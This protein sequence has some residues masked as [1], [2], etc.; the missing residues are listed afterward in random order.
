V[1]KLSAKWLRIVRIVGTSVFLIAAAAFIGTADREVGLYWGE[2]TILAVGNAAIQIGRN[3]GRVREGSR[4]FYTQHGWR[5]EWG[6]A[7]RPFHAKDTYGVGVNRPAWHMIVAP[8]W[9]LMPIGAALAAYAHGVLVGMRRV[10]TSECWKCGYDL[11]KTPVI[12]GKRMCPECGELSV[13]A[14]SGELA[15]STPHT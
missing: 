2:E 3:N 7:W 1:R 14:N 10:R 6:L 13:I 8:V 15:S 9:P 4:G 5:Q 11:R 12:D